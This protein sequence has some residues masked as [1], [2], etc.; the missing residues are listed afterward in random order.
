MNYFLYRWW[1]RYRYGLVVLLLGGGAAW[2]VRLTHGA[3]LSEFHYGL[4][5][6]FPENGQQQQLWLQSQTW[7]L[8]Q[9]LKELEAQ[10]QHLESLLQQP[11][12]A[13]QKSIAAKILSR[14][15][16]NWWQQL[17]LAKGSKDGVEP[18]SIVSAP[19]GLVGRV[20]HVTPH[21]SR[22]LLL[23]DPSSR[24]GV[25]AGRTREM[26]ILRGQGEGLAV[27]EFFEK[28]PK[29][30]P[31]DPVLTS[32]LS[33]LFPAKLPIGEIRSLEI[34]D[35][36]NPRAIVQLASPLNDLEWVLVSLDARDAQTMAAPGT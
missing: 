16:D 24:I 28:D 4:S 30:R 7:E 12:I 10:N 31:G 2:A 23:T 3:I 14:S 22:V 20:T 33:S 6:P 35:T 29:V 11:A 18:G 9:R 5:L 26:G 1:E 8:Q 19:G 21:T 15:A 17:T 36:A 13:E 32:E 27:L 34:S 25:I